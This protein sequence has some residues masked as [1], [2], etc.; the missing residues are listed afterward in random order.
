[1]DT[2]AGA[3]AFATIEAEET[4]P[5][6]APELMSSTIARRGFLC[7]FLHRFGKYTPAKSVS[8]Y[9]VISTA[10]CTITLTKLKSR[11]NGMAY[12]I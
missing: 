1:M 10:G 6:A 11:S 7:C 5:S 12:I 4:G 2:G 8:E 3:G 9:S